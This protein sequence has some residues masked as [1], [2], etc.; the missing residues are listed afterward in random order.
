LL[1]R[2]ARDDLGIL[3]PQVLLQDSKRRSPE[4]FKD[5]LVVHDKRG[6]VKYVVL[7]RFQK[8]LV[9]LAF[10]FLFTA[11]SRL[12]LLYWWIR[13]YEVLLIRVFICSVDFLCWFKDFLI[14]IKLSVIGPAKHASPINF[15]ATLVEL[16]LWQF[17]AFRCL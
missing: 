16:A 8:R 12:E 13:D 9:D 6:L 11:S 7:V 15:G 1:S 14:C 5:G 10:L 4:R 17:L 2:I 3:L